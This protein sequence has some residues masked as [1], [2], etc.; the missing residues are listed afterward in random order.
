[1]AAHKIAPTKLSS[2]QDYVATFGGVG[3]L[4][5]MPGSYCSAI[6]ALPAA[7]A[8]VY[9]SWPVATLQLWY[10]VAFLVC[11]IIGTWSVNNVQRKWGHDP[12]VVVIDEA[13]GMSLA[14]LFPAVYQSL[15]T[16]AA[17]V[18]VFR[19]FD[20]LKPWPI[21]LVNDR[22]EAW[23]VMGD[24]LLAAIAAGFSLQLII[25]ALSVLGLFAA[26]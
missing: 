13:A 6:V 8:I 12:S 18:L 5:I 11:M 19:V 4:P 1:M 24:D 2:I 9:G 16:W 17:M 23:A 21:N 10:G 3:L 14:L 7:Y 26:V 15:Y 25:A 22:T 20:V